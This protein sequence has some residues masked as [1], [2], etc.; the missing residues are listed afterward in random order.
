MEGAACS[1]LVSGVTDRKSKREGDRERGTGTQK[2]K[3]TPQSP[4]T[5]I[6]LDPTK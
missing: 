3:Q 1:V 5:A 6:Q 2:Q 4:R